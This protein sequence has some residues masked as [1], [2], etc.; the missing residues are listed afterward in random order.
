MPDRAARPETELSGVEDEVT[1]AMLDA[2]ASLLLAFH[3]ERHDEDD[4][5][6]RIYLAMRQHAQ[7]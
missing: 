6:K 4:F 7:K 3:R 2:G 5:V 1:P